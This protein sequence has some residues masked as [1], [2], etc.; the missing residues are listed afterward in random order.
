MT[1]RLR[2]DCAR[3][4][5]DEERE[6]L[7]LEKL[8][9]AKKTLHD[10][11]KALGRNTGSA[12][13][14]S[15]PGS[16]SFQKTSSKKST[17]N[18]DTKA[19]GHKVNWIIKHILRDEQCKHLKGKGLWPMEFTDYDNEGREEKGGGNNEGGKGRKEEDD[20]GIVFMNGP[21]TYDG[22]YEDSGGLEDEEEGDLGEIG[23][24]EEE[25]G[26][27]MGWGRNVNKNKQY[28]AESDSDDT[29]DE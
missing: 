17:I 23:S 15:G 26:G 1:R 20:D 25:E 7:R 21:S 8:E 19:G 28:E 2:G 27:G 4:E 22:V 3:E 14:S 9:E 11:G 24:E 5:E 16:S 6:K 13:Q 10:G 18:Q 12:M 29:D